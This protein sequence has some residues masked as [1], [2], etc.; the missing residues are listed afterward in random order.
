MKKGG[1]M[2][3]LCLSL[4]TV[5]ALAAPVAAQTPA[6][7]IGAPQTSAPMMKTFTSS[8]EVQALIAKAK[9]DRKGDAPTTVEPILSLAPYHANLEYRPIPGPAAVH[10]VEDEVM[11]VI[12]GSGTITLGGQ[13]VNPTRPNPTNQSADKISGGDDRKLAKGDFLI[14]PHGLAHQITAVDRPALVLMTLHMPQ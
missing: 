1:A 5:F 6:T 2:R 9:A 14:V 8:A 7:Q 3:T 13:M 11:Y 10:D 4:L 12:E